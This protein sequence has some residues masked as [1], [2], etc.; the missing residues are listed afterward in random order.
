MLDEYVYASYEWFDDTT[1]FCDFVLT[2]MQIASILMLKM[3]IS[4]YSMLAILKFFCWLICTNI[5]FFNFSVN[6]FCNFSTE[7]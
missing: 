6:T 5:Y 4:F 7:P 2:M 3:A 1:L